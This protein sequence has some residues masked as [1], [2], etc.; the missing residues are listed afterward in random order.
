MKLE[1]YFL[2]NY[3]FKGMFLSLLALNMFQKDLIVFHF[4]S[5]MLLT[6][7]KSYCDCSGGNTDSS[8]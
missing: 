3:N 7:C 5:G 4:C 1:M 6:V 8:G 2:K